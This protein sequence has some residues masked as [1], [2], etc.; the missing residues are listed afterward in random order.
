MGHRTG[1]HQNSTLTP[2]LLSDM[3]SAGGWAPAQSLPVRVGVEA[4]WRASSLEVLGQP[5]SSVEA[6]IRKRASS[7]KQKRN[8][9]NILL[10]RQCRSYAEQLSEP[11]IA[12]HAVQ[13][14][15]MS[16][17]AV[18]P[19]ACSH[20]AGA[21]SAAKSPAPSG[22]QHRYKPGRALRRAPSP[23]QSSPEP[24]AATDL[25]VTELAGCCRLPAQQL[26]L[27]RAHQQDGWRCCSL[28]NGTAVASPPSPAAVL[29]GSRPAVL[30]L[31]V[32]VAQPAVR[33][34]SSIPEAV[35]DI[36]AGKLVVVLDSEDRE[37]EGDLIM[38]GQ[39]VRLPRLVWLQCCRCTACNSSC[40]EMM[41]MCKLASMG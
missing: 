13:Q 28:S 16:L 41:C 6:V 8:V 25:L 22:C 5:R 29:Q 17:P 3:V 9:T 15:T 11:H 18:L 27:S 10:V 32:E 38:T 14:L 23:Q 4:V 39:H 20:Q 31:E 40:H 35:A 12:C 19:A 7:C 34:F 26:A 30:E 33:L 37:N 1:Q 21:R 24:P 36:A 2:G